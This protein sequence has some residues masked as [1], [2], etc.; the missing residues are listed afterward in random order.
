MLYLIKIQCNIISVQ[1]LYNT[2]NFI[3]NLFVYKSIYLFDGENETFQNSDAID[4]FNDD[5]KK[6]II[7]INK[8]YILKKV[9]L[10]I[11]IE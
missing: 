1:E 2:H 9:N 8:I 6:I 7:K 11:F 10:N 5:L 3:V 4:Y